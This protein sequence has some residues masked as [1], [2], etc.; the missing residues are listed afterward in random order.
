LGKGYAFIGQIGTEKK[1]AGATMDANSLIKLWKGLGFTMFPENLPF[2]GSP[3]EI[4]KELELFKQR[5]NQDQLDCFVIFIE[6]L[7]ESEKLD[8]YQDVICP[9]Q[10][11]SSGEGSIKPVAKIFITVTLDEWDLKPKQFAKDTLLLNA[12]IPQ[13]DPSWA[14]VCGSDF[15]SVLT[16]VMMNKARNTHILQILTD[17]SENLTFLNDKKRE[18]NALLRRCECLIYFVTCAGK[19]ATF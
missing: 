18:L 8:I 16:G 13:N 7:S 19:G 10:F 2:V 14:K 4:R 11:E 5:C 12:Q 3:G 17:V 6:C 9:F 15:V 1:R